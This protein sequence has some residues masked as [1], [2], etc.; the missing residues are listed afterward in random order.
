VIAAASLDDVHVL[1]PHPRAAPVPLVPTPLPR[2][3]PPT[4]RLPPLTV[5]ASGELPQAETPLVSQPARTS[6]AAGV[7]NSAAHAATMQGNI[8]DRNENK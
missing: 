7:D 5:A 2:V 1:P 6:A 3:K 8:R 4:A